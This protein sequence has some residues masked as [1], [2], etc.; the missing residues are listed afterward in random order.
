MF[1]Y[2]LFVVLSCYR[3][4]DWSCSNKLLYL[5][6]LFNWRL[7]FFCFFLFVCPNVLF[8]NFLPIFRIETYLALFGVFYEWSLLNH[9]IVLFMQFLK[10][11]EIRMINFG[12]RFFNFGLISLDVISKSLGRVFWCHSWITRWVWFFL[13]NIVLFKALF[14]LYQF[15]TLIL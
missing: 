11:I 14:H 12:F 13:E 15:R 10:L 3:C 7:R 6:H 9:L 1:C 5:D 4:S 2:D 8:D